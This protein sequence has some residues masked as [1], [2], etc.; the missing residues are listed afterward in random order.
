MGGR[1]ALRYAAE[2]PEDLAALVIE[3]MECVP[4]TWMSAS[5]P[6]RVPTFCQR[7]DSIDACVGSLTAAGYRPP[8][9]HQWL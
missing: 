4:R 7:F 6:S 2:F 1:I 9:V 5:L 3:D 8:E